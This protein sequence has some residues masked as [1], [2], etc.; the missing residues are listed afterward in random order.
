MRASSLRHDTLTR[1]VPGLLAASL[2]ALGGCTEQ[3]DDAAPAAIDGPP[4]EAAPVPAIDGQIRTARQDLAVALGLDPDAIEVR[5]ALAVT[6]ASGALGCPEPDM[7]YPQVLT[8]GVLITLAH[9]DVTYRY[10]AGVDQAPFRCPP[11][12]AQ[13]PATGSGEALM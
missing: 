2:L 11:E 4:P 6:W 10:H 13:A 7:N 9:R 3:P 5:E 1:L 8:H 12:R